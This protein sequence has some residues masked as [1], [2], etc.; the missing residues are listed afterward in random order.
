MTALK[1]QLRYQL[2]YDEGQHGQEHKGP[3]VE[4]SGRIK[5]VHLSNPLLL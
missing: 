5:C 1:A 3:E 4:A 2:V